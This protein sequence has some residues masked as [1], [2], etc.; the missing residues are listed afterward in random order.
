MCILSTVTKV[1]WVLRGSGES[2]KGCVGSLYLQLVCRRTWPLGSKMRANNI[3]N[4]VM[5]R[6]SWGS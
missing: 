3:T 4:D 6:G 2:N 1:D 5:C